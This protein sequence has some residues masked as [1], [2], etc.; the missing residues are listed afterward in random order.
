MA[1]AR[2]GLKVPKTPVRVDLSLDG[3][4]PRAVEVYVTEHVS[5]VAG[6]QYVVELMVSEENFLPAREL[7]ESTWA[8]LNKTTITWVS[9][10]LA[11]GHVPVEESDESVEDELFEIRKPI[12]AYLIGGTRMVGELLYSPPLGRSRV[13][14]FLN[15]SQRFFRLWTSEALYLVNKRYV[16]RVI[17]L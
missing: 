5:A 9:M 12:A 8:L 3:G 7:G 17:E 4:A 11:G 2:G 13:A 15:D 16:A 1:E 14:D 10:L 6:R